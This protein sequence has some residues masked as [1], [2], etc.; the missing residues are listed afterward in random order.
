MVMHMENSGTVNRM[1]TGSASQG[2]GWALAAGSVLSVIFMMYHPAVHTHDMAEFVE[3]IDAGAWVNGLVHGSLIALSGVMVYGFSVLC[4]HL[5]FQSGWVRAG[6]ISYIAGALAMGLAA[7][8]SGFVI[9]EVAGYY[10]GES[11]ENLELL[12]HLLRLARAIN[13]VS[14]RVGV[15]ALSL[16]VLLW[17]VR[18]WSFSPSTRPVGLLGWL[19][20]G[21]P[22]AAI[23]TGYLPMNIHGVLAYLVAQTVWTLAAAALLIRERV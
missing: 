1:M 17:S 11:K 19:C 15:A 4:A 20:G 10:Q 5:G 22:L 23:L 21:V 13:Q 14:S 12:R 3:K 6:L 9:P 7:L 18:L 8:I 16:A 2:A